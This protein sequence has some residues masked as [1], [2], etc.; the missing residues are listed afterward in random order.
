MVYWDDLILFFIFVTIIYIEFSL[1][2]NIINHTFMIIL[3]SWNELYIILWF[4]YW[5]NFQ[6]MFQLQWLGRMIIIDLKHGGFIQYMSKRLWICYAV[7]I[8]INGNNDYGIVLSQYLELNLLYT[9]NRRMI[10]THHL[11]LLVILKNVKF[12]V[13]NIENGIAINTH[14]SIT[15]LLSK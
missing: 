10:L 2:L 9:F 14:V 12:H 3:I 1:F 13:F 15:N 6:G 11:I 7:P 8:Y 5:C 4:N